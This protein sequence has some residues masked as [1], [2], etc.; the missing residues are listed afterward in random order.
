MVS[1][2]L[3]QNVD[4]CIF[5]IYMRIGYIV[6]ASW[7]LQI[8]K[9]IKVSTPAVAIVALFGLAMAIAVGLLSRMKKGR[10]EGYQPIMA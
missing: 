1:A 9:N 5:Y 8:H 10:E 2:N 7:F 3:I 4:E 6:N